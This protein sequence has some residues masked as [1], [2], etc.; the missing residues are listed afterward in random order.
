MI[1]VDSFLVANGI[2]LAL[3][4]KQAYELAKRTAT[5]NERGLPSEALIS[6]ISKLLEKFSVPIADLA[7]EKG[8]EEAYQQALLSRLSV[9]KHPANSL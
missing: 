5:H 9:R 2:F 1:A 8:L 3:A 7:K 6:T 4:N